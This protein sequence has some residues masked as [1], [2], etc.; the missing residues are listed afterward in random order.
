MSFDFLSGFGARSRV[1]LGANPALPKLP[2]TRSPFERIGHLV[3]SPRIDW[4]RLNE[5]V[6][7]W[8]W[9]TVED[10]TLPVFHKPKDGQAERRRVNP[11]LPLRGFP[12]EPV[13]SLFGSADERAQ[14][15]VE[16][17]AAQSV[18]VMAAEETERQ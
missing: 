4:P 3:G 11:A 9:G 2:G 6:G 13:T 12:F 8:L 18:K 7:L 17:L 16:S 10:L 1:A 14:R 5:L 15:A